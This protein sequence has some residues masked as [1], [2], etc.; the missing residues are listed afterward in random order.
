MFLLVK[1]V[2]SPAEIDQVR[3]LARSIRFMDGRASNPNNLAK[4]NLQADMSGAEAQKASQIV[5]AAI[6]AN[7]EVRNFAFPKRIATPLLSRYEPGMTYGVH[8]DAA[9]L[10]LPNGPLR[11]DVSATLFIGDPATYDGGDLR[12]HLGTQTV[13]I[14]GNP[15]EMIVY[16]SNTLHEVVPVT[17]GERLAFFT[18]MESTIPNHVE[19]D[20]LY[21]L[22][23]VYALEGLKMD[24]ENR[25]RLQYVSSNLTKMWSR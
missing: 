23:E 2:L 4:K 11:S 15:G 12:I 13:T 9:Y 5:G 21:T 22:N 7:E 18:F 24:W 16:P 1:N 3:Q 19:R 8:S 20:L 17:R 14:K 10:P 25:T 6:A